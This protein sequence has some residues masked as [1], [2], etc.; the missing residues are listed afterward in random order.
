MME[1]K[2]VVAMIFIIAIVEPLT[3]YA[4]LH[5]RVF[6]G[7][8]FYGLFNVLYPPSNY[9]RPVLEALVVQDEPRAVDHYSI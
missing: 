2:T 8:L 4:N 7:G 9:K 5:V 1:K 6:S 3:L